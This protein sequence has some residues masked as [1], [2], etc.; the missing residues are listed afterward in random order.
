MTAPKRRAADPDA[1]SAITPDRRPCVLR[2]HGDAMTCE[3][4]GER[5]DH[6]E[7][8]RRGW[9]TWAGLELAARFIS[10]EK[11]FCDGCG[12][13]LE[14]AKAVRH[15]VVLDGREQFA[16]GVYCGECRDAEV[17]QLEMVLERNAERERLY[18]QIGDFERAELGWPPR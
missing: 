11:F 12:E 4:D 1:V 13:P 8:A 14:F 5:L 6:L 2:H 10:G 9:A 15:R 7:L 17:T 16:P 3:V 18:E